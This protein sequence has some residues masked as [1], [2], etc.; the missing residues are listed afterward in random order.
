LVLEGL[1]VVTLYP[2][3]VREAM[4]FSTVV[5]VLLTMGL[6]PLVAGCLLLWRGQ[7]DRPGPAS[8]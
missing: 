1:A 2:V 8:G 7:K 3:L 4:P 6:P 5:F